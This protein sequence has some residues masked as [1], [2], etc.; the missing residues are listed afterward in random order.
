MNTTKEGILTILKEVDLKE[1]HVNL[2][3]TAYSFNKKGIICSYINLRKGYLGVKFVVT[4]R[5]IEDLD[6]CIVIE[7]L[8]TPLKNNSLLHEPEFDWDIIIPQI[9]IYC[10]KIGPREELEAAN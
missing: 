2:V 6:D 4:G 1:V 7:M 5:D 8:E 9:D 10:S 3:K